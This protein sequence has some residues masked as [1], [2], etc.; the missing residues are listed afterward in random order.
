MFNCFYLC[1]KSFAVSQTAGQPVNLPGASGLKVSSQ[2][3]AYL[4]QMSLCHAYLFM[5]GVVIELT[6]SALAGGVGV[7][8]GRAATGCVDWP[9][10]S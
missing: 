9:N 1:F 5:P 6:T 2:V 10:H 7:F 8:G 3:D 4:S